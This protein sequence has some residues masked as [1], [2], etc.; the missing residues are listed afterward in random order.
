MFVLGV[1]FFFPIAPVP[2]AREAPPSS[3]LHGLHLPGPVPR[4]DSGLVG[5]SVIL[6]YISTDPWLNRSFV[7]ICDP[8]LTIV[9][10]IVIFFFYYLTF[11]QQ[12][13]FM[14]NFIS[15]GL[16]NWFKRRIAHHQYGLQFL[17]AHFFLL[18]WMKIG[19]NVSNFPMS[20]SAL[21]FHLCLAGNLIYENIW[22]KLTEFDLSFYP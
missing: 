12:C 6:T 2:W 7:P 10:T 18:Q 5:K 15:L 14:I 21:G 4:A 17:Q 1:A 8:Y 9:G 11:S 22:N 19:V 3:R 20:L 13:I 16:K